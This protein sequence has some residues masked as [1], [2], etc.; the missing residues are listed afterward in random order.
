MLFFP[1]YG[2]I[3]VCAAAVVVRA[4]TSQVASSA[5]DEYRIRKGTRLRIGRYLGKV[6]GKPAAI[7]L[8]RH[9]PCKHRA[10]LLCMQPAR[11]V[12]CRQRPRPLW[13]T[14]PYTGPPMRACHKAR[15]GG[16]LR[17]LSAVARSSLGARLGCPAEARGKPSV[18]RL[19]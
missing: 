5:T 10:R 2:I 19:E 11:S 13:A 3:C 4:A 12:L 9:G 6:G 17:G 1:K 18:R 14:S 7:L 15:F 16:R 8:L